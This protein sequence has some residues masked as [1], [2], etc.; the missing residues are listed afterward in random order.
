M[1]N[2][3]F[4]A[5]QARGQTENLRCSDEVETNWAAALMKLISLRLFKRPRWGEKYVTVLYG[6]AHGRMLYFL[7]MITVQRAEGADSA[8]FFPIPLI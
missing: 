5:Y 4:S 2:Y 1:I 3:G 7:S 6:C 8:L